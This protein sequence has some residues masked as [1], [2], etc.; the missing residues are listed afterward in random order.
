MPTGILS[1]KLGAALGMT[2]RRLL[3]LLEQAR[4][5]N[6]KARNASI[7]HWLLWRRQH[8]DWQPGDPYEAPAAK[9][10]RAAKPRPDGKAKDPPLGPRLFLSRELYAVATAAAPNLAG[11]LASCCVREVIQL[12]KANTP[13]DHDGDAR[14]VW[15]AILGHEVSLPK[16][17]KGRIPLPAR[18]LRLTYDDHQCTLRFPLLSKASGYSTLSPT[19]RLDVRT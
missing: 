17:R 14:W 18:S 3:L 4:R 1:M 2:T 12:L 15:Q 16:W 9:I 19:V 13:Y 7:Q 6:C 8:P 11:I 10:K 5:D